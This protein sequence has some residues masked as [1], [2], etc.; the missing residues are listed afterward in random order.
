MVQATSRF[1]FP[2]TDEGHQVWQESQ[3]ELPYGVVG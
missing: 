1:S 3:K 2:K